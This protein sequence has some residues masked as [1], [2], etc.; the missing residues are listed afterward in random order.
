MEGGEGA[1]G[2][3]S[4]AARIKQYLEVHLH[5][6]HS[7]IRRRVLAHAR[8]VEKND[9][10][11]RVARK[12]I[13]FPQDGRDGVQIAQVQAQGINPCAGRCGANEWRI[14]GL[15]ALRVAREENDVVEAVGC[16]SGSDM[17]SDARAGAEGYKGARHDEI[18]E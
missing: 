8:S 1:M 4:G 10:Y 6:I 5:L 16:E 15:E 14:R 2:R 11:S 7:S 9:F 3:T 12:V 17:I 13:H 18:F